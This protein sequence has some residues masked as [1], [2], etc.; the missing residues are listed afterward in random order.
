[1]S[2]STSG[3]WRRKW[4]SRRTSPLV[5]MDYARME[6]NLV[7]RATSHLDEVQILSTTRRRTIMTTSPKLRAGLLLAPLS[8]FAAPALAAETIEIYTPVEPPYYY[9]VP[10]PTTEYYYT[11]PA[12]YY[13]PP[14][15]YYVPPTTDYYY[16]P[17]ITVYGRRSTDAA[18]T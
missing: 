5:R 4:R 3:V 15:T 8:A 12:T 1:M 9:Y 13:V 10:P 14:T 2:S 18:I 11:P 16:A 7:S 17:P 6:R